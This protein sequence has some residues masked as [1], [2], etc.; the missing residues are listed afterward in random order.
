MVEHWR[1]GAEAVAF[2]AFSRV[3]DERDNLLPWMAVF[4]FRRGVAS[5]E[6]ATQKEW[7]I[8]NGQHPRRRRGLSVYPSI[9]RTYHDLMLNVGYRLDAED[10][11]QGIKNG[12]ELTALVSCYG[13]ASVPI[14]GQTDRVCPTNR[15]GFRKGLA[16][17]RMLG[18][19]SLFALR[20]LWTTTLSPRGRGIWSI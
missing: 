1:S 2:R 10:I 7:T 11:F 12:R 15:S 16:R 4:V 5:S 19:K 14:S 20:T 17:F 8:A 13:K 9:I 18:R 3:R 6:I